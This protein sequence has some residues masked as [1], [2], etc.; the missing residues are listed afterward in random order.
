MKLSSTN[1][2][3]PMREQEV[4]DLIC[5][6]EG[7]QRLIVVTNQRPHAVIEQPVKAHVPEAELTVRAPQ[8]RLPVGAQRERRVTATDRVLPEVR[9]RQ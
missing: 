8:L 1:G 5:I 9:Q 4:H 6:K 7:V 3:M 2:F